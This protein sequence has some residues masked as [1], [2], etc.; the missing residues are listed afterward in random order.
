VQYND[1]IGAILNIHKKCS[2]VPSTYT[3]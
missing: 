3:P 2:I 1:L